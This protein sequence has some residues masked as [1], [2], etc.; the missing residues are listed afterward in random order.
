MKK[1]V[2]R[3][4]RIVLATASGATKGPGVS[5]RESIGFARPE[6]ISRD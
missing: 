5:G 3:P 1:N 2:D 4:G 6:G